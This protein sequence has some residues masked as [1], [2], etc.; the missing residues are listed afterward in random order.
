[1]SDEQLIRRRI[2]RVTSEDF[3]AGLADRT[4]DEVRVMR[5]E[6]REEEARLSYV[7]R[8]LHGQLDVARAE[9]TRRDAG[10][11]ESLVTALGEILTDPQLDGPT[12]SAANSD[13]YDPSGDAGHRLG[14]GVLD[15]LPLATLPEM[16]DDELV[17]AV[18]T[19]TEEERTI[20]TLRRAVLD[21]LD[22]LQ[23]ELITRYR[24]GDTSADDVVP[25]PAG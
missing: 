4:P 9:L 22:R 1:M 21:N 20:S 10:T 3:L 13:L 2:D 5:D 15:D 16:T 6:C 18:S 12:R 7:R 11:T 23:A 14:D 24:D 17:A 19:L 8:L 25:R